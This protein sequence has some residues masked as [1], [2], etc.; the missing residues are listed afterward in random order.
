MQWADGAGGACR[1]TGE[2]TFGEGTV[3]EEEEETE[4]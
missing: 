4:G 1:Y 2:E 3:E